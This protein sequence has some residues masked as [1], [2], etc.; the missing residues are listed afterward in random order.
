MTV[1]VG[2]TLIAQRGHRLSGGGLIAVAAALATGFILIERRAA[3]PLMPGAALRL[4]T[5][6]RGAAGAL[7]NTATTSPVMTLATLYLQVARHHSPL[8]A[9]LALLPFS[10]VVIA[11]SALAAPALH[12]IP[13]H[14][15]IAAGLTL[16]ALGDGS[17]IAAARTGWGLPACVALAGLG[18]G[19]SSVAATTLGT[20]VPATWR[21]TAS[22]IINTAAQLGSATGIA[23]LLLV[24]ALTTGTTGH[25]SA[26]PVIAWA[27]AAAIAGAGALAFAIQRQPRLQPATQT[28]L[29]R[30]PV[31]FG[32]LGERGFA[33]MPSAGEPSSGSCSAASR[34]PPGCPSHRPDPGGHHRLVRRTCSH[35]ARPDRH[36]GLAARHPPPPRADPALA[37]QV[38]GRRRIQARRPPGEPAMTGSTPGPP[39]PAPDDAQDAEH[40]QAAGRLR[41]QRPSWIVVW[42][43]PLRRYTASP[44]H[45]VPATPRPRC[46]G[47]RAEPTSPPRPPASW[48][49]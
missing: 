4:P 12:R 9:G 5:L 8:S 44:L 42:S 29:R 43:A 45:R 16:I 41:R 7:L 33:L 26:G 47:H 19:L 36:T 25:G 13:A 37:R 46:S 2:T 18:I 17:L 28:S 38:P 3:S 49:P 32:C 40:V 14:R 11:G 30:W 22:G 39:D 21:G 35:P 27:T 34:L 15:V 23:A 48:P 24:A 31:C 10:L 20:D 1:I 6:R